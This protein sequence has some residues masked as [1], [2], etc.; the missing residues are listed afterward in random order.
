[1]IPRVRQ[2]IRQSADAATWL[3]F[4]K[5]ADDRL[6]ARYAKA[7]ATMRRSD[8]RRRVAARDAL[9]P[10]TVTIP[11]DVGFATSRLEDLGASHAVVD[12][13]RRYMSER[14]DT[15]AGVKPYL[16]DLQ[17]EGMARSSA[18]LDLA[19]NPAVLASAA[20]YLGM[21]PRLVG[22]TVLESRAQPGEPAGSQLFHCDYE[23]VRQVKVFVSCSDVLL[24]NGPLCAI[25]ATESRRIK[26][27]IRY[28][29]GDSRFRVP[30]TIVSGL[31]PADAVARFTGPRGSVTF[32]DT[33][34]C[35]HYG[36]RI[37]PG[38]EGRLALQ[39]QYLSP[40]AFELVL[41][42]RVRRPPVAEPS[43]C[44]SLERLVLGVN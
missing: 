28:R 11:A 22:V 24:E 18:I 2:Q 21:V 37:Q 3:L 38:A 19:L 39:L 14:A 40:A 17:V 33:C 6:R 20:A 1:M 30:D 42:P 4:A 29:Y 36:S 32:I 10:P 16:V 43:G 35:F 41:A 7:L 31:L 15:P 8:I 13:V 23:D 44:T 9:P 25:P 5:I 12:E 34:S 26:Q 27:A